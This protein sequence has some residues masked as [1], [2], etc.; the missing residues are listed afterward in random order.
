[1]FMMKP[2]AA[3]TWRQLERAEAASPPTTPRRP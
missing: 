2:G 1:M 3:D